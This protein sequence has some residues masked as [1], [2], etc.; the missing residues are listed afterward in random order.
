VAIDPVI[1]RLVLT[2][3]GY[4]IAEVRRRGMLKSI[5]ALRK[6][7]QISNSDDFQ[8][9]MVCGESFARAA[10]MLRMYTGR[11]ATK[12]E[13]EAMIAMLAQRSDDIRA[14]LYR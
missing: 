8:M 7:L 4:S 1:K 13:S 10:V 9:G 11:D 6:S 14:S 3:V 12:E 5:L 2:A